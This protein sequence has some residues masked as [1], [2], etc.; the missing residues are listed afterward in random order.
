MHRGET[1]G[2]HPLEMTKSFAIV[3]IPPCFQ[4]NQNFCRLVQNLLSSASSLITC[5][6]ASPLGL[7]MLQDYI[8]LVVSKHCPGPITYPF[9]ANQSIAEISCTALG[10]D[11]T[12][13]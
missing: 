8:H 5:V 4:G 6:A 10:F 2:P 3:E 12:Q 11:L 1:A 7:I 13:R 9:L